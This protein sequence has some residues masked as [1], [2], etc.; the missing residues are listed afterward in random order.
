MKF[1]KTIV[2]MISLLLG[3]SVANAQSRVA[4]KTSDLPKAIT[5]NVSTQHPGYVIGNAYRVDNKG[6]MTY[7]VF[8][9]KDNDML[10]LVYDKDGKFMRM[11]D[12]KTAQN[13][14]MHSSNQMHSSSQNHMMHSSQAKA[15]SDPPDPPN[16]APY[17]KDNKDR[18]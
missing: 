17:A 7:E 8:A 3:V 15:K 14:Q 6:M 4:M 13:H 16:V 1:M 11:S 9:K 2:L 18:K 5:E 10:R 12:H